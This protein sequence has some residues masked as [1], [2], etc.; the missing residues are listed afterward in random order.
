[1]DLIHN[2]Q[3]GPGGGLK[4]S[5]HE[6]VSLLCIIVFAVYF[7]GIL[8]DWMENINIPILLFGGLQVLGTFL[9]LIIAYFQKTITV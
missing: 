1:M 6:E 5:H 4:R 2:R 9:M 7:S 3:N 8:L